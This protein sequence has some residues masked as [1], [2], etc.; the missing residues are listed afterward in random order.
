MFIIGLCKATNKSVNEQKGNVEKQPFTC[1]MVLLT[2]QTLSF[3]L[4]TVELYFAI[5]KSNVSSDLYECYT[6]LIRG[7]LYVNFFSNFFYFFH[8]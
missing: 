2:N 7:I 3:H 5:I 8:A 6:T 4:G 1:K